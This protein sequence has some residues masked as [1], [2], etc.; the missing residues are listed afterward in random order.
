MDFAPKTITREE[1]LELYALGQVIIGEG[2]RTSVAQDRRKGRL[3]MIH[4]LASSPTEQQRVRNLVV[5]LG[6]VH[7]RLVIDIF[8]IDEAH[9]VVTKFLLGF[10]SFR[11]WLEHAV[12]ET[13][14]FLADTRDEIP[15]LDLPTHGGPPAHLAVKTREMEA[16]PLSLESVPGLEDT[17]IGLVPPALS[18][19][20][21]P[22]VVVHAS[23]LATGNLAM[24]PDT[25]PD[26]PSPVPGGTIEPVSHSP[27]DSG[28]YSRLFGFVAAGPI[29]PTSPGSGSTIG[30]K[31]PGSL[32]PP[33]TP[34]ATGSG[35]DH[36][37]SLTAMFGGASSAGAAPIVTPDPASIDAGPSLPLPLT[38]E[39]TSPPAAPEDSNMR[40]GYTE[41]FGT[42]ADTP[43][44][45]PAR[46]A[47]Q[48]QPHASPPAPIF[49]DPLAEVPPSVH[50]NLQSPPATDRSSPVLPSQGPPVLKLP[51]P[52]A[53][54]RAM[55]V[56]HV[57]M[58]PSVRAPVI[59]NIPVEPTS[60]ALRSSPLGGNA[61]SSFTE[62][63]RPARPSLA[64]PSIP[65]P[66]RLPFPLVEASA[67]K[68]A[69]SGSVLPLLLVLALCAVLAVALIVYVAVVS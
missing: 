32:P 40:A 33:V 2:I 1:F 41:F 45:N 42:A 15:D 16:V 27:D 17:A 28:S 47:P 65:T 31:T 20:S 66:S 6:P 38:P 19:P 30:A 13:S 7:S 25:D 55:R 22:P 58:A 43:P 8:S 53:S 26:A 35:A 14:T 11:Q 49:R 21:G 68:T 23:P 12:A 10:V 37:E 34:L 36:P 62:M 63:L 24:K 69:G 59:P 64:A 67:G 60:A 51:L 5:Q 29:A 48:V 57:P 46:Q 3:V 18:S 39:V 56:P 9:I 4:E 52:A 54:A 50:A 44:P 61:G